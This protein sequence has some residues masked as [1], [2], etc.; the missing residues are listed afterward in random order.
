M[1][2]TVT[3]KKNYEFKNLLQK[4]KWLSGKYVV[5]YVLPQKDEEH[6]KIGFIVSRK[7]G[8]SVFRNRTRRIL[9]QAYSD[10]EESIK[11]GYK[12]LIMWK[13]KNTEKNL[14]STDIYE[15]LSNILKESDM[16]I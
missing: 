14:K 2:Y 10:I 4:G 6:N 11:K 3:L 5:L 8:N 13:K 12:I 15:D 1:K 16:L 7:A 9:R